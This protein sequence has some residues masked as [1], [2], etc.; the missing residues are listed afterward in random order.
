MN[1]TT[2]DFHLIELKHVVSASISKLVIK[3]PYSF[4]P[5]KKKHNAVK[6][7]CVLKVIAEVD[8]Y[9]AVLETSI[10]GLGA[11]LEVGYG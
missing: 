10:T 5:R 1:G 2:I 9:P 8:A 7:L 3:S 6:T 11:I 4:S